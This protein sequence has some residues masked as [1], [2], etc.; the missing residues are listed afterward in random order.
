MWRVEN[1]NIH[2]SIW[3]WIRV[4]D[5]ELMGNRER[6]SLLKHGF[7]VI[8]KLFC[9]T[10][11][12]TQNII[13]LSLC[14]LYPPHSVLRKDLFLNESVLFSCSITHLPI[15]TRSPHPSLS[16]PAGWRFARVWTSLVLH[17]NESSVRC[18]SVLVIHTSLSFLSLSAREHLSFCQTLEAHWV[19]RGRGQDRLYADSRDESSLLDVTQIEEVKD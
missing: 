9:L 11:F 19:M 3:I 15:W 16:L 6:V 8:R 13:Q 1:F 14:H 2:C 7:T 12:S 18:E 10:L 4:N 17:I 5:K